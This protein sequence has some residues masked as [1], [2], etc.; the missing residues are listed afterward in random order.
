LARYAAQNWVNKKYETVVLIGRNNV[1]TPHGG[2]AKW[3][4]KFV[5]KFGEIGW[6]GVDWI[7]LPQ[8]LALLNMVMNLRVP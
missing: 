7:Y 3:D 6:E 4:F 1:T 8:W 5:M 2:T